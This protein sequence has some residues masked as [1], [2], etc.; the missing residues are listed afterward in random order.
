MPQEVITAAEQALKAGSAQP[1]YGIAVLKVS[2][3]FCCV[4]S[5]A[6]TVLQ[7]K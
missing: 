7:G 4:V 6:Y 3:G 5:P 1:G 2:N